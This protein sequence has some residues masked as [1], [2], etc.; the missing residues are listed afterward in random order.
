MNDIDELQ[1]IISCKHVFEPG[2]ITCVR[3]KKLT[4]SERAKCLN[5]FQSAYYISRLFE[6]KKS[7]KIIR[8]YCGKNGF[9]L[10]S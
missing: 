3:Q 10:F 8:N 6:R 9:E 4:E 1:K 7:Q 5:Y 2:W